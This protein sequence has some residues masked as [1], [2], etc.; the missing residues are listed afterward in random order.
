MM[1]N[2]KFDSYPDKLITCEQ[3]IKDLVIPKITIYY[4]IGFLRIILVIE[5]LHTKM[6]VSKDDDH[7]FLTIDTD[8][9][10]YY[11]DKKNLS[12]YIGYT[13]HSRFI[14]IKFPLGHSLCTDEIYLSLDDARK[15]MHK[16][17]YFYVSS[18]KIRKPHIK[19]KKYL[20]E[21]IKFILLTH[22]LSPSELEN[23]INR[24]YNEWYPQLPKFYKL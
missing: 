23:S 11:T 7:H 5:T 8:Y 18:K 15:V 3:D 10:L 1:A 21:S 16:G 20:K 24:W 13:V 2:N 14:N 9:N 19:L 22:D 6:F 12:D 4:P 17:E